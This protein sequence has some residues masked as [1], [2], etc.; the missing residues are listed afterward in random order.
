MFDDNSSDALLDVSNIE[1]VYNNIILVLRGV[2]PLYL[3]EM[4]R[5][6]VQL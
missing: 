3:E 6:R 4:V 2:S 5:G 1:V